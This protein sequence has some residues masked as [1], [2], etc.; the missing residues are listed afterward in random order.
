M[1]VISV[2]RVGQKPG[3]TTYAQQLDVFA[4]SGYNEF[5]FGTGPTWTAGTWVFLT[6]T[7]ADA[8]VTQ[9]NLNTYA[10]VSPP[11][12]FTA[13]APQ[14]DTAGKRVTITLTAV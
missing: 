8:S 1:A 13:G 10:S 12:G 11:A 9:P 4:L 3:F 6:Y 7:T 2:H 14:L 5:V